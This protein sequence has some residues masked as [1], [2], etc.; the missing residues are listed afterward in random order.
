[1]SWSW[2]SW[3]NQIF[4]AGQVAKGG[5]VRRSKKWV[6]RMDLSDELQR[7]VRGN[8]FHMLETGDQYLIICNNSG[9]F[10]IVC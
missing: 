8:G 10:R 7:Q 1:M 4:R 9:D 2:S 5:I 6:L 3:I